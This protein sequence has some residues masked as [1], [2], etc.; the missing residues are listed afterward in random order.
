MDTLSYIKNNIRRKNDGKREHECQNVK[1]LIEA[2][3]ELSKSKQES[4]E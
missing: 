1:D 2:N 4:R 3:R